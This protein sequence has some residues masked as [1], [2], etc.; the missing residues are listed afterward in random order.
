MAVMTAVQSEHNAPAASAAV[1]GVAAAHTKVDVD[2]VAAAVAGVALAETKVDVDD[3]AAAAAGAASAGVAAIRA[4]V[5]FEQRKRT[6]LGKA[7]KSSAGGIDAHAREICQVINERSAFFTTSSCSGRAFLWQ[8]EGVK[9]T[10][11]FKRYRVTHELIENPPEHY[12]NLSC[13]RESDVGEYN[14][15]QAGSQLADESRAL[16]R[17]GARGMIGCWAALSQLVLPCCRADRCIAPLTWLRFEPFILHVCCCNFQAASVL[18]A[19]ARTVFKNVGVQGW[20]NGKIIVAIWGDEGL[21]MPLTLPNGV[22]LFKGQEAWLQSLVN[23]RHRRNW[24][25]ID[26]FVE[27]V[28]NMTDPCAVPS[29]SR[30]SIDEEDGSDGSDAEVPSELTDRLLKPIR[31]GP[32]HYDIIGDVALLHSAP[33]ADERQQAGA[34]ILKQNPRLSVVAVRSA[35][36][37]TDHRRPESI[38]IIAGRQRSPLI[39]THTEFGIRYVIDLEAIFFSTRMSNERQ[40]LCQLVRESERICVLFCG[41]G[42]EALQLAAKTPAAQVSAIE[43]NPAAVRCATR[44]LELLRKAQPEAAQKLLFIEGDVRVTVPSLPPASFDRVVA[45]RPKGTGDGD[46]G[47]ESALSDGGAEFL[48]L[49]L[50]LLR[51]GGECHWYD[52]AADWELPDCVRTRAIIEQCCGVANVRCEVLRCAAA[53]R[54]SIAERQ[55]RIVVDF[56][57]K[58]AA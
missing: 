37:G 58:H 16:Q 47:G 52:F 29:S 6:F 10:D 49:L 44:S 5:P 41:C 8:G 56:R 34:T 25:K 14:F 22:P 26:R 38:E 32:K 13:F 3:A 11:C 19:A 55:Y 54:R 43:L 46:G 7:D 24:A 18:I 2:G 23:S 40:R 50:P 33:P 30:R 28:R 1:A 53:N 17:R 12:F 36:L 21:D 31:F 42:P 35:A 39:T 27:A 51:D 57:I 15:G 45:P 4:K 9:S 20:E 48:S